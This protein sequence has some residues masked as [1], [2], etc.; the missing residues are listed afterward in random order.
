MN[1]SIVRALVLKDL[2]L[3]RPMIVGALVLGT[4]GVGLMPLGR[5]G[6]NVGWIVLMISLLLLGIFTTAVGVLFERKERVHV[7]VLT[8]PVSPSQYTAAKLAAN[9]LAFLAPWLVLGGATM[10]VITT[11]SAPDGF[12]P[13]MAMLLLYIACYH[14][15]YLAVALV[16]DS[17]IWS[18]AVIILGNTAP[19][20]V[21]PALFRLSSI[22]EEAPATV[23][24]WSQD[25]FAVIAS[26][27]LFCAAALGIALFVRSRQQDVV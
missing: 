3:M 23:A 19:I 11:T 21:I 22:T 20:F 4:I 1:A 14:S 7:F 24:I 26:E 27:V 18:T 8:L 16:T 9:G 13:F 25:V 17:V 5:S 12:L 2:F 6:F 10:T 15:A